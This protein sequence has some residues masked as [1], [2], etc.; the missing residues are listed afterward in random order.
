MPVMPKARYA[1]MKAYMPTVGTLGLDMMFRTATVQANL[2]FADEADMALKMRVS[3][4]LQPITTALFANSPFKEGRPNGFLSYRSHIWSDTDAKRT[5][6]LPFAFEDGF[7]FEHYVDFALDAPMYFIVRDGRLIDASGESFR[8]F[9]DGKLPQLPG[10]KPTMGDWE[11]HLSTIFPEVRLK[12]FLEMRGADSGPW[13]TLCAMP[14]F[15]TGILYDSSA[16][17]AAW[18][19]VK[20]WTA[21]ERQKLRDGVPRLGLK[22]PFRPHLS[23]QEVAVEALRIARA[24]LR[25]RARLNGHGENEA[26]FLADLEEVA[27]SGITPAE[28]L[29]ERYR[30]VWGR[31]VAPVFQE[32]AF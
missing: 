22:T 14:A 2:D 9:L 26:V 29:L 20:D 16:L 5:G 21:E 27:Q 18:D 17:A 4:A 12:T 8:A 28:R 15:W 24:G 23:A 32:M 10:Q 7:G 1:I 30:T 25:A 13:A 6:M 3:L 31:E 19:M 11:T